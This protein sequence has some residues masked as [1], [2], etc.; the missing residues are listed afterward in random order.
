MRERKHLYQISLPRHIILI[1]FAVMEGIA[2]VLLSLFEG[3]AI[4][5]LAYG[6]ADLSYV[7]K[8]LLF[9]I[10]FLMM[11]WVFSVVTPYLFKLVY[12]KNTAGIRDRMLK[13]LLEK[14][15]E[16][17]GKLNSGDLNSRLSSDLNLVEK[18]Y[19]SDSYIFLRR[20]A[21]AVFA[22]ILAMSVNWFLALL[23]FS[24]LPLI[25]YAN[26]KID[27]RLD[28]NYDLIDKYKGQMSDVLYGSV[29]G[30]RIIK[31]YSA[32]KYFSGRFKEIL[33]TINSAS[34]ANNKTVTKSA[35]KLTL[36][37]FAP[38]L[39]HLTAGAFF[40]FLKQISFGEF[41][42]FGM[43]RSS[44]S[45]FLMFLPNYIPLRHE[46]H[47]SEKRLNEIIDSPLKEKPAIALLPPDST[48]AIFLE[49]VRYAYQGSD[50]LR[51][52][53]LN[54]KQGSMTVLT[55]PSGSGKTSLL[56]IIM[57]FYKP[58]NGS[59]RY[60]PSCLIEDRP[61]IAYAGQDP[62]IFSAS[63]LD[64]IKIGNARASEDEITAVCKALDI[65][66][67]I[68]NLPNQFETMIGADSPLSLSGGQLQRICIARAC[69]SLAP[70]VI[71]DEPT[72][73]ID[74]Q[75]EIAVLKLLQSMRQKKTLLVVTHSE[76]LSREADYVLTLNNGI[77]AA[78]KD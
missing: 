72:S 39:I 12:I 42:L 78:T 28:E 16:D 69:I 25:V 1:V 43:L 63:I 59:V 13:G 61:A 26:V 73:A 18:F 17:T 46:V 4:D 60:H 7:Q 21:I 62:F 37:N 76:T 77:L 56:N 3:R 34:K 20:L 44:V 54:I 50:V 55:G 53:N 45:G 47:A 68:M 70:V 27:A 33:E 19:S 36:I 32:R 40:V 35:I 74:V 65:Y 67:T 14:S 31:A 66:D 58:L 9:L 6:G 64:N 71:M 23:E 48:D 41:M 11:Q 52:I 2:S 8:V 38:T 5:I 15:V 29:K 30:A 10:L 57:G 49:N 22:V 51:H 24:I 75:N